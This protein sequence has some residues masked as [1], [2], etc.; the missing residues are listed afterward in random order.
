MKLVNWARFQWDLSKLPGP[1]QHISE[2]YAIRSASKEE[3]NQVCKVVYSAFSLDS[4]WADVFR[5]L[6]DYFESEFEEL[7]DAENRHCLVITHGSRIIAASALSTEEEAENHLIT[8]PCILHEYRNR[9]LGSALLYESLLALRE[10]G[11]GCASGITR[12][13]VPA[14]RFLYTKYDSKATP[15]DFSALLVAS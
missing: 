9:G 10:N 8:G 12:R 15:C 13:S 6:Q 1:E 4:D 11:L 2:P 14:G 3:A 5:H 7:F